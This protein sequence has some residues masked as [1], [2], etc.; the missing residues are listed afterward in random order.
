MTNHRETS[1]VALIFAFFLVC[2]LYGSAFAETLPASG[3][4]KAL[5]SPPAVTVTP[6]PAAI[7]PL[8]KKKEL[9]AP[10]VKIAYVDIARVGRESKEGKSAQAR[11]KEKVE[12]FQAQMGAKQKQLEKQKIAIEARLQTMSPE[13]KVAKGKEFEKKLE[14]VRKFAQRSEKELQD[15]QQELTGKLTRDIEAAAA[16]FGK[17]SSYAAIV[18]KRDI[19]FL[20]LGVEGTDVTDDIIKLMNE[21]RK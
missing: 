21:E 1:F 4:A 2:A 15:M 18:V 13:Q 9:A 16:T 14:A 5:S 6:A 7:P 19:L 12:K 3:P 8:D 20:G 17:A 10:A 11:L